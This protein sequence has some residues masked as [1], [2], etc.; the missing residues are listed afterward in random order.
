[1]DQ[2]N[3]QSESFILRHLTSPWDRASGLLLLVLLTIAAATFAD[4]GV[5]WDEA[6]RWKGG[7]E[8]LVYYQTLLSGG[9]A[10]AVLPQKDAYPGLFDLSIALFI[11]VTGLGAMQVGHALSLFCGLLTLFAAWAIG[12]ELGGPRLAFW[13]LLF[14]AVFPRFYGHMFFNPKD[15]PFAAGMTCSLYFLL[16]WG[17]RLP[18]PGWKSTVLLG[19]AVGLTMATRI[20]GMVLIS[21]VVGY[22]GYTLIVRAITER[23]K[24]TETL[25]EGVRLAG[26][27]ILMGAVAWITLYP[28]WPAIHTNPI[29]GP[30][31]ALS[32]V[33]EYPWRG[34]VFFDGAF[35]KAGDIPWFYPLTWLWI[36]LP[37]FVI[38]IS[39]IGLVLLL[40]RFRSVLGQA[41]SLQGFPFLVVATAM[42]FPLVYIIAKGSVLYD[43]I[44][45][46]LFI[47]PPM[48]VLVAFAWVSL[49]DVLKANGRSR[50]Y[51][52]IALLGLCML[53]QLSVMVRMHPYEYVYFN[54]LNGGLRA[55][56]SRYDTE[57]WAT[58][59]REVNL[60]TEDNM[61]VREE[62]YRV[63][64]NLP[65]WLSTMY[66]SPRF[67]LVKSPYD[68]ELFMSI[69]RLDLD[70]RLP[71]E[72][73]YTVERFGAPF[74]VVKDLR[75]L[76]LVRPEQAKPAA[77]E[78]AAPTE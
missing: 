36:T 15:I 76:E 44:R 28:W 27:M 59:M 78:A 75:Q 46:L 38:A 77:E 30:F 42:L 32:T 53:Y 5:S 61:P 2:V 23:M 68:A 51:V 41:F 20:G 17:R 39:L 37:D 72:T 6:F 4:Y 12:R 74:A 45:H 73:L 63:Y 7:Q 55:M 71:G 66:L 64:S 49:L 21:Y 19:V 11:E 3:K 48:A 22:A 54:E 33:S 70:K 67:E 52:A 40:C 10:Q 29:F 14:L 9:D 60:W 31:E 43:G 50:P 47:L 57:Y 1:M 34:A 13:T 35:I 58:S 16:R 25:R 18:A 69:T 8:K 26:W 56:Q 62:P 24:L 65:Y